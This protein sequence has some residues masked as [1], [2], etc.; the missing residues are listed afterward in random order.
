LGTITKHVCQVNSHVFFGNI[1]VGK[2]RE[3]HRVVILLLT[4]LVL[5]S[6]D[7]ET[8]AADL[9][10]VDGAFTDHVENILVRVRVVFDTGPIQIT[11]RQEESEVKMRTGLSTVPN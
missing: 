4:E 9:A 5:K 2:G 8:L 11:I 1:E 10:P 3:H 6:D 7:F